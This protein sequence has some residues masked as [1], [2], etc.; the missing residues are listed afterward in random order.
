M[1]MKYNIIIICTKSIRSMLLCIKGDTVELLCKFIIK[2]MLSLLMD[3]LW[4]WFSK[5]NVF[6]F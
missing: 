1:V 6:C 3:V 4:D 2:I 5:Y